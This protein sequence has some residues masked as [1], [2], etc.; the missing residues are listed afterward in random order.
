MNKVSHHF[1]HPRQP[2]LSHPEHEKPKAP[3]PLKPAPW[4]PTHQVR[5]LDVLGIENKN[6]N[7]ASVASMIPDGFALGVLD[8]TFGKTTAHTEQVL[9]TGKVKY[10]RV[11]LINFA[12]LNRKQPWSNEFCYKYKNASNVEKALK[13]RDASLVNYIQSRT[14]VWKDVA[15]KYPG[16]RFIISPGLEHHL[17]TEAYKTMFNAVKS[18]W[19]DVVIDGAGNGYGGSLSER[20]G[21]TAG[22]DIVSLDGQDYRNVDMTKFKSENKDTKI[23]FTW[24]NNYN[25][26][27]GPRSSVRPDQRTDCINDAFLGDSIAKIQ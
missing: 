16:V 12:S 4:P 7:A 21:N 10:L 14:Q 8:A 20:H 19:P 5:G 23:L 9:A 18:V 11:H 15:A 3:T 26:A 1:L 2:H 13:A 6:F 24:V 27:N 25:C 22:G 17:G